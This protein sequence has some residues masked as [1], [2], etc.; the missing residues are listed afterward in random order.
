[1]P[2]TCLMTERGI[3]TARLRMRAPSAADAAEIA[4]LLGNWHVA[5]WL[6]RVPYP[7]RVEHARSWIE[8][9]LEERAEGVGWPFLIE[10]RDDGAL[11][12]SID[13]SVEDDRTSGA[14][15]YWLGEKFWGRGYATE[16]AAV[17]VRFAFEIVMLN[18]VTANVLPD[19]GRSVRVLEKAGFSHI[20]RREEET[21]ERGRVDTEYFLIRRPSRRRGR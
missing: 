10:R 13:L 14:I 3:D 1:M 12:G 5:H 4:L 19:N 9:S 20:G 11:I 6:V 8:R 2:E 17:M 18:Q 16:A 15:G 21:Y 7:Y